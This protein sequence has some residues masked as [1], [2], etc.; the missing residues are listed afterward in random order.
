MK[1][2]RDL[3]DALADYNRNHTRRSR[4]I[5]TLS[6][7]MAEQQRAVIAALGP[8]HDLSDRM[9]ECGEPD[10]WGGTISC[11]VPLCP[12]CFMNRRA[13]ETGIAIK[14]RFE[15]AR[16]DDLAFLTILLPVTQRIGEI[17]E[18]FDTEKRRIRN[19]FARKRRADSR[20]NDV[21]FVSWLEVDRM[22]VEEITNTGR[23]S[24]LFFEQMTG[25]M[26]MMPGRTVWRPHLHGVVHLG[27]LSAKEFAE[28]LRDYGHGT[29]Y[30]V[31]VKPFETH[32]SVEKNLQKTIRY[33]MKFRIETD[34]K[35]SDAESTETDIGS[36]EQRERHWW[37]PED[38]KAFAEWLS[39]E[40]RGFQS[41]RFVVNKKEAREKKP[42]LASDAAVLEDVVED[43]Y[44]NT[45]Q[46]TNWLLDPL[47]SDG[48][49]E[50]QDDA[51][52]RDP[53][54]TSDSDA[55]VAHSDELR[56]KR[57]AAA[58]TAAMVSNL[59]AMLATCAP[60]SP[61]DWSRGSAVQ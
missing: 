18:M 27:S 38:I 23:N 11:N 10:Q 29:A 12:R 57:H 31:D 33:S 16:N 28:T 24:R 1:T 25:P 14:K 52:E 4:R 56:A 9:E 51:V 47:E 48:G 44:D 59:S 5:S 26:M 34:F 41:L 3:R 53:A 36:G 20:W 6:P 61:P 7:A 32:R 13:K 37:K 45:I 40:R 42:L 58:S 43:R 35:R 30:Q 54:E 60:G 50:Q 19:M 55:V 21:H 8:M 39:V 46:D 15:G 17:G 2:I 22:D 49:D